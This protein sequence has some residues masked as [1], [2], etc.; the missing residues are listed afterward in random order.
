MGNADRVSS[1]CLMKKID[2]NRT[3]AMEQQQ[4]LIILTFMSRAWRTSAKTECATLTTWLWT[5][6]KRSV[7]STTNSNPSHG[8]CA[9][10][11][12][13]KDEEF[14]S[15][16]FSPLKYCTGVIPHSLIQRSDLFRCP[17]HTPRRDSH[18]DQPVH[19]PRTLPGCQHTLNAQIVPWSQN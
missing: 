15:N 4:R 10:Q 3:I 12:R 17:E 14:T 11:V 6:W 5:R 7:T 19:R 2:Q 1:I 16:R 13:D 8:P 18:P 9:S